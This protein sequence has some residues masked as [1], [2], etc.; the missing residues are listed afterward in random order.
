MFILSLSE[1]ILLFVSLFGVLQ[2]FLL[3]GLLYFHPKSDRSVNKFL[4]M[5]ITCLCIIMLGPLILLLMPWH[6]VFFMEPFTYLAGPLMYLYIRSYKEAITWRKALPHIIPFFLYFFVSY[7]WLSYLVS[8]YAASSQPPEEA[9]TTTLAIFLVLIRYGQLVLY[10]FMSRRQLIVYQRSIEQLFSETSRI[11][12]KWVRWLIDG[13]IIIVITTIVLYP[14]MLNYQEHFD[15][16]YLINVVIATP[17][18]YLIA[19]KGIT[20]P[21]IWQVKTA[22][23]KEVIEEQIQFFSFAF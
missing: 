16:L 13:Y 10:Y 21:T 8:K 2:G 23:G 20:Q 17:Y 3:A 4:A 15:L 14:L 11:D 6:K 1:N 9:F 7:W 18:I 12:L 19:Y 5:Y 22:T